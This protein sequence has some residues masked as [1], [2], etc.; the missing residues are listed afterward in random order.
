MLSL[1]QVSVIPIILLFVS[2]VVW[3]F[4]RYFAGM[5][6]KLFFHRFLLSCDSLLKDGHAVASSPA[7]HQGQPGPSA[8]TI[9][10]PD[11]FPGSRGIPG[12]YESRW[13]LSTP[14][15]GR[16]AK[17][18]LLLDTGR[19]RTHSPGPL[20]AWGL[21]PLLLLWVSVYC[22]FPN[23]LTNFWFSVLQRFPLFSRLQMWKCI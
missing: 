13:P 7:L 4:L 18:T 10:F 20:K 19:L 2:F 11:P 15:M 1:A 6:C 3:L 17:S 23:F 8:Q 16:W 14:A 12:P 22:L 9:T 5:V 21:Q